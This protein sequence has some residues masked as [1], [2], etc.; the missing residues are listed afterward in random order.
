[1]LSVV[2]GFISRNCKAYIRLKLPTHQRCSNKFQFK[3]GHLPPTGERYTPIT[4]GKSPCYLWPQSCL[5]VVQKLFPNCFKVVLNVSSSFPKLSL[6]IP[7]IVSKFCQSRLE[8]ISK[9][10][11]S[12]LMLSQNCLEAPTKWS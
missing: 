4:T 3:I 10:S 8:V 5:R 11:R 6:K 12:C 1:M 9:F 2:L 7:K